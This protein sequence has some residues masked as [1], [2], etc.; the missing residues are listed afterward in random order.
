VGHHGVVSFVGAEPYE[1]LLTR[2]RYEH[3]RRLSLQGQL[4]G[5]SGSLLSPLALFAHTGSLDVSFEP[6][7]FAP[8]RPLAALPAELFFTAGLGLA[9]EVETSNASL[10]SPYA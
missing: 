8:L 2:F 3:V 6:V 5:S 9:V 1:A 4:V 7:V 10:F